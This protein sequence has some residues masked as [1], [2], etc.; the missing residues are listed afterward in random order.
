[1][2]RGIDGREVFG[3]KPDMTDLT[4]RLT[5]LVP[6]MGI[7]VFAWS[8]MPNHMH[9]LLRTG[10]KPLCEF[11]HRLLTGYA[12]AYNKRNERQGHVFQGRF[13]SIP[14]QEELYFLRLIG[15]IHCNP[16][17]AGLV[18]SIEELEDCRRCGHGSIL[19]LHSVSWHSVPY[20]LSRL[21][22]DRH[23]QVQRYSKII[24]AGMKDKKSYEYLSG[25]FSLGSDGVEPVL[26]MQ[27]DC[28]CRNLVV[29]GSRRF[30]LEIYGKV[31]R[32]GAGCLRNRAY[33]HEQLE[34]LLEWTRQHFGFSKMM[35]RGE[36]RSPALSDARAIVAW[37]ASCRLGL[38]CTDCSRLLNMSRNGIRKAISRGQV[39][40]SH[41]RFI[42]E[43]KIW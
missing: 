7:E 31:Q 20:V 2:A 21:G 22:D 23:E 33:S 27:D 42:K 26:D 11:M 35:L 34:E 18:E 25:T 32:S 12:V 17:K 6:E 14:V 5:R 4:T 37:V 40:V 28:S 8:I 15:Y 30:A 36:T 43:N 13:K 24:K 10:K 1:M 38:S 41:S 3:G 9:L 29:L 39:I 19:G 16:I